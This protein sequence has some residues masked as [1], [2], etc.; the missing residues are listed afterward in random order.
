VEETNTSGLASPDELDGLP[1][2]CCIGKLINKLIRLCSKYEFAHSSAA[3]PNDGLW[4][5][6][7]GCSKLVSFFSCAQ[8]ATP[9]CKAEHDGQMSWIC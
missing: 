5:S 1:L 3:H 8:P 7:S 6:E 4:I 9:L 2:G